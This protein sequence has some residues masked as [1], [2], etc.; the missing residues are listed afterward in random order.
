MKLDF[1]S[2]IGAVFMPTFGEQMG[3][4]YKIRYQLVTEIFSY[5]PHNLGV[6]DLGNGVPSF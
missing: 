6:E 2:W 3:R 4:N 5:C 1:G